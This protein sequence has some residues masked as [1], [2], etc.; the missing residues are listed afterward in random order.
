MNFSNATLDK[1][2]VHFVGNKVHNENL[3]ISKKQVNLN[4]L[5]RDKLTS[6]FLGKFNT[7]NEQYS[8][9]HPSGLKYNEVYG[10]C[11]E[12]FSGEISFQAGATEIA[13]HL[14]EQSVHPKINAG[15]LYICFFNNCTIDEA[16]VDGIGIFKT[17]N[18][19]GFFE[20]TT[21]RENSSVLYKEGVDL[22]KLDKGC[23]ILNKHIR[24]GYIVS[25]IDNQSRGELAQYWKDDFLKIKERSD[26]YHFTKNYLTVAKDF[27]VNHIE[28]EFEI[29][30]A[31]KSDLLNKSLNYFKENSE[32]NSSDFE[33][34][35]FGDTAII[36]SFQK[37]GSTY[38][39]DK[40]IEIA[41][42]FSISPTAV[43]KQS[44]IFKSV[45]KLDNNFH[46]YIHGDR[47]LIEQGFDKNLGKKYYKIYFDAES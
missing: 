36:E 2:F 44:R 10:F 37:F 40:S 19:A 4:D 22:N 25:I 47:Q 46:I 33:S 41:D 11:K 15:E 42:T 17:E 34:K 29:S 12:I 5:L 6:Y 8:F 21:G 3:V 45:I 27:I 26:E 16:K 9:A 1:M 32:F 28:G 43:R 39:E 14:Y 38:L 7:I 31:D 23:I 24:E 20:V 13:K 18:K 30:K 35:V